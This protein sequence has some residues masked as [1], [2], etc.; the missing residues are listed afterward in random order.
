M[1]GYAQGEDLDFSLRARRLGRLIM[2]PQARIEHHHQPAGRPDAFRLGY[3]ELRNRFEIHRR[4]IA[5]RTFRDVA[6]FVYA[7]T[8]DTL[9]LTR[10]VFIRGRAVA[11]LQQIAGRIAAAARLCLE[12]GR[13][14]V[15]AHA[16]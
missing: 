9:L 12:H 10:H 6:W 15:S 5:D 3:M 14:E 11:A 8:I 16:R 13:L 7:W 4:A 2:L 1:D